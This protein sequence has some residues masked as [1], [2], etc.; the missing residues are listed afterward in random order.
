MKTLTENKGCLRLF[1]NWLCSVSLLSIL[2]LENVWSIAWHSNFSGT[3]Q[4]AWS[5]CK[6]SNMR[7]CFIGISKYR[8]ESWKYDAQQSIYD[9]IRGLWIADETTET[10]AKE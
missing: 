6:I 4:P 8:E 7:E 3:N 1:V 9:E 2:I 5:T 10:K